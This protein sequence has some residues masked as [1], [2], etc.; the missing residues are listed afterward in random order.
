M[1]VATCSY[2]LCVIMAFSTQYNDTDKAKFDEYR[3]RIDQAADLSLACDL[4][5]DNLKTAEQ[6][7]IKNKLVLPDVMLWKMRSKELEELDKELVIHRRIIRDLEDHKLQMIRR[8]DG[9]FD[10]SLLP[11]GTSDEAAKYQL[12]AVLIVGVAVAAIVIGV[13]ALARS[14]YVEK[15]YADL[16]RKN[17]EA[18]A[19]AD[20]LISSQGGTIQKNW[21]YAKK[22]HDWDKNLEIEGFIPSLKSMASQGLKW[23]ILIAI[24][25]IA[26]AFVRK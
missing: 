18:M 8:P 3:L 15:K 10:V 17:N 2:V 4:L 5:D 9:D 16:R 6:F 23:G 12:G 7:G 20:R 19:T 24:P 22:A 1:D 21:E 14:L 11:G 13:A 25:L 26:L